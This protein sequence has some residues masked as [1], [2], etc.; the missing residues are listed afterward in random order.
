[1]T[2][3]DPSTGG[4]PHRTQAHLSIEPLDGS[5]QGLLGER[6]LPADHAG[7]DD[8]EVAGRE[9]PPVFVLGLAPALGRYEQPP[10]RGVLL[11]H[12][13]P[14]PSLP[15]GGRTEARW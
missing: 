1:I 7:L 4:A 8:V 3:R 15:C 2:A 10:A 9:H 12:R 11:I 5:Q 14:T 6:E 13:A